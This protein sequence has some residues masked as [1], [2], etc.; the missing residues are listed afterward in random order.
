M[1][2]KILIVEDEA[3][4]AMDLKK[5]LENFDFEVVGIASRGEEAIQKAEKF[6]P[7]LILMDIFLKGNMDGIEAAKIIM[8]LFDIPIIYMSAFIDEKIVKNV[9]FKNQYG[10]LNKPINYELL[11]ISIESAIYKHNLNKKLAE[12]EEDLKAFLNA[13]NEPALLMELDGK[14]IV[15]NEE[16]A[17]KLGKTVDEIIGEVI[18]NYLHLEVVEKRKKYAEQSFKTGESVNFNERWPNTFY[19]YRMYPILDKNRK[20][21]RLAIIGYDVT[22]LK[23]AEKQLKQARD[24]LEEQVRK[25]TLELQTERDNLNTVLNTTKSGTYIINSTYELEYINPVMRK[26]FG[27]YK[28][29]KCYEYFYNSNGICPNCKIKSAFEGN[30]VEWVQD[31]S[32]SNKTYDALATPI[33]KFDGSISVVVFLYD[34]TRRDK[35]EKD[36]MET[37]TKLEHSN[38]EL[39]SFTYISSHDL[40]EPLR[41]IVSYAQ[42]LQRRYQ[43]RLD[44]DADD[45]LQ[46]MVAGATRMKQQINGILEYSQVG[47]HGKKFNEINTKIILEK[48]IEYL[49]DDIKS[50]N[51]LI[52]YSQLPVIVGDEHQ[53]KIVFRNLIENALKFRKEGVPPKIHISA[54]REDNEYIFSVSDNGIGIEEQYNDHIFEVFKQLHAIDEYKGAGIGLAIVKRIID[55]HNGR[56]WVESEHGKGS[57]FYFSLPQT[58]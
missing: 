17:A 42:L 5:I 58:T 36:L 13:V 35:A 29:Q 16:L 10:F 1:P 37:V 3:I 40:Q 43:G 25:R 27:I 24:N 55:R 54:N 18:Y 52:T 26:D 2:S 11:I 39:R 14:I 44:D 38:E 28:G 30:V 41:S 6:R 21:S 23:N 19:N 49:K 48:V 9:M 34:V 53:I 47:T 50:S 32:K 22:K 31:S 45:F 12:S 4:T 20:V 51:A 7:D 15:A 57:T 33:T 8:S 56:I 46:Y